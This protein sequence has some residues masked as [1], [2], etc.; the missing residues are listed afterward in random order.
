MASTA[1]SWL[2]TAGE[3]A[4]RGFS[5]HVITLPA[6]DPVRIASLA[7]EALGD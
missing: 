1:Q 6:R 2:D 7:A 5:E 4:R 3:R